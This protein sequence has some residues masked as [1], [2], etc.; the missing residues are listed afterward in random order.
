MQVNQSTFREMCAKRIRA[1]MV[2]LT[3]NTLELGKELAAARNSFPLTECYVKSGKHK[4]RAKVRIGWKAWLK[5]EV[6]IG[7]N[8]AGTLIR[9]HEKLGGAAHGL[10]TG[11]RVLS[12][13][14]SA[15]VP[16][17]A[18]YELIG[19]AK[20]GEVIT[21]KEAKKI[22]TRHKPP[23]PKP[24]EANRIARE[25]GKPTLA[26]DNFYYFGHTK[27]EAKVINDRRGVVFAVRRAIATLSAMEISPHQF[28]QYALP[29]QLLKIDD[30]GEVAKAADWM[31]A[32]HA[33]WR[34]RK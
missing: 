23:L 32:F 9:I 30:H 21:A 2:N 5:S 33:A 24:A 6:G 13:L 17:S 16:A 22:V 1:L 27:A 25:T 28:L 8:H 3:T 29:H 31:Q 7:E 19:R 12:Y 4:K 34:H 11:Q 14:A 18:R 10:P 15:A 20:K 26:S